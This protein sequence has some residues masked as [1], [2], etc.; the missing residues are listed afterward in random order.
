[1][2]SRSAFPFSV[3]V[4]VVVVVQ[5]LLFYS[6]GNSSREKACQVLAHCVLEGNLTLHKA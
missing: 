5:E 6:E 1:M 4:I 3:V 2:V